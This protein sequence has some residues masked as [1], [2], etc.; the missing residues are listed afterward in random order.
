M[1]PLLLA[2][3]NAHKTREFAQ[4]L[5]SEFVLSDLTSQ[6]EIPAIEE[7]GQTFEEN[8][9]LKAVTISK[10][11]SGLVAA[12][13]SGLE[14]DVLGGAPGIFSARYSG[15]SASDQENIGKLLR[16]LGDEEHRCARFRCAIVLARDGKALDAFAGELEGAI[17]RQPRG[18][19]G[20]GYDPVF[21]PAGYDRTFAELGEE[22][23][24][25]ISHRARAIAQLRDYLNDSL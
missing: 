12:D 4:I 15:G 9:A 10:V 1:I 8:A 22:T 18:K 25:R 3:R 2:T 21:I 13:D 16:E 24:N 17:S 14:V 7:T 20:F 19:N 11:K 23:K 5:G 6:P